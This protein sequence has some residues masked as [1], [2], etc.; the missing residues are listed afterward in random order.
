MGIPLKQAKQKFLYL[1]TNYKKILRDK[2]LDNSKLF[3]LDIE[4]I[5]IITFVF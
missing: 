1:E 4:S 3:G 2:F 5:L